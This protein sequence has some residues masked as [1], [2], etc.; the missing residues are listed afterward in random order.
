MIATTAT[1]LGQGGG[2]PRGAN[3]EEQEEEMGEV[4]EEGWQRLSKKHKSEVNK[5]ELFEHLE[6]QLRGGIKCPNKRCGC[7]EILDGVNACASIVKYLCWFFG[8]LKYE[9]E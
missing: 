6:V 9:Q 2:E 7:L 4:E 8:K 1:A 3:E 5:G